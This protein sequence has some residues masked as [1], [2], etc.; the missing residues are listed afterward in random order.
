MGMSRTPVKELECVY[1]VSR[2]HKS[3]RHEGCE[4]GLGMPDKEKLT[5]SGPK[6]PHPKKSRA[7]EVISHTNREGKGGSLLVKRR[8]FINLTLTQRATRR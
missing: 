3:K 8:R 1:P 4:T 6:G 5:T 7:S 2:A